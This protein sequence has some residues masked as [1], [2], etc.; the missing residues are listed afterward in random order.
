MRVPGPYLCQ[1]QR[2]SSH[3]LCKDT[4]RRKVVIECDQ[5]VVN[6]VL[7]NAIYI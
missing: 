4:I 7:C 2:Q 6:D 3:I 5:I 1:R